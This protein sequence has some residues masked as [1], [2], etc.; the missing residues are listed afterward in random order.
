MN[1]ITLFTLLIVSTTATHLRKDATLFRSPPQEAKVERPVEKTNE[2]T[3]CQNIVAVMQNT[4]TQ[5]GSIYQES[6]LE[7]FKTMARHACHGY[8]SKKEEKEC[9]EI[10]EDTQQMMDH[11][12]DRHPS[13]CEVLGH[14][15]R[16]RPCPAPAECMVCEPPM[17]SELSMWEVFHTGYRALADL[18]TNAQP[19]DYS[20]GGDI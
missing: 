7:E 16:C 1:A 12:Y 9:L 17:A 11:L 5:D 8:H 6:K 15:K 10:V 4:V 3:I 20:F 18:F 2:C 14:C 19:V 13:T